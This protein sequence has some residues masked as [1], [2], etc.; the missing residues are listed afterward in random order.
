MRKNEIEKQIFTYPL[1]FRLIFK[2][3]N[4]VVTFI[5]VI[6]L[7]PLVVYLDQ[8][9]ILFIPIVISLLVIYFINRFYL[10]LYKILPY[11]IVADNEK[12]ICSKFFLSKKEIIIY[13]ENIE[14]LSGGTFAN[15]IS[16]VMKICDGIN[17]VCIGFYNKLINSN[18]LATIIL[19]KVNRPLYDEVLE[20]LISKNKKTK[21]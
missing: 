14:S 2:F 10:N 11:K 15:R 4:L 16:G 18:K 20:K 17:A 3:G 12:L 9:N 5:L 19:S 13:Y 8:N 7:V 21:K 1:F 6:Y